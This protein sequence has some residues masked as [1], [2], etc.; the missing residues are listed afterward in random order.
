MPPIDIGTM[1]QFKAIS[2][3]R[4]ACPILTVFHASILRESISLAAGCAATVQYFTRYFIRSQTIT[5]FDRPLA[6]TLAIRSKA[7]EQHN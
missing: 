1:C 5:Q 4:K 6:L 7:L 2:S 3:S